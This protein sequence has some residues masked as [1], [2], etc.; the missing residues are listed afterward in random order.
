MCSEDI[1]EGGL[2]LDRKRV[3]HKSVDSGKIFSPRK[4]D[5]KITSMVS[6]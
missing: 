6:Q 3:H 2:N 4:E 5:G 1:F